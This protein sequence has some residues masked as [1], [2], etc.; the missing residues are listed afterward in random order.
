MITLRFKTNINCDGCVA[1]VAPFLN[2]N[3]SIT[4]WRVDTDN[5]DKVLTV[6]GENLEHRSIIAA[7]R[8]AGYKIE[9]VR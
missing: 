2:S 5:P 3:P 1:K 8:T 7:I 9:M 6:E 4:A